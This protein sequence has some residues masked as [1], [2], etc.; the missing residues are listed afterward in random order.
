[1]T[2]SKVDRRLLEHFVTTRVR[3]ELLQLG[4]ELQGADEACAKASYR[5]KAVQKSGANACG[6]SCGRRRPRA[7]SCNES[8]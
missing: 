6:R 1:M 2:K 4:E 5:S 7:G 3:N 8:H